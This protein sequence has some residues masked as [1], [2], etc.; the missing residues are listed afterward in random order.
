MAG[1][2]PHVRG[3]APPGVDI[4]QNTRITPAC[5]GKRV[6]I[7]LV[8]T[9]NWDH[10]RMCGEKKHSLIT[11]KLIMG[12]PP[13]VRGKDTLFE[14]FPLCCGITPACAG[15]SFT[16]DGRVRAKQDHPRMCGEKYRQPLKYVLSS[17][18]P[19]HVRGKVI[20]FIWNHLTERI[21]PACAGKRN[22]HW[23]CYRDV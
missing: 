15:K 1:S 19:P 14:M 5:A 13:H 6:T 7:Y 11:S 17:G 20:K 3:K 16:A 18:S 10:P 2:P 9:P 8:A 23:W 22:S 21:T 12:S 4:S